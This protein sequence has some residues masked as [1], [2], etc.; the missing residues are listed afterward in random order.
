MPDKPEHLFSGP[1]G[2]TERHSA[3]NCLFCKIVRGEVES[4]RVFEDSVSLAF[5]DHRPLFPG[6][7]L[8]LPKQHYETLADLPAELV[9]PFFLNAQLLCRAVETA[10]QAEGT[11]AGINNCVSQSVPHLH[12]HI[13]PRRH[14]DGMR[15]FFWPRTAYRAPEDA[16]RAQQAI[17]A[18][19]ARLRGEK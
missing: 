18:A 7:C 17:Q 3:Q 16:L 2:R 19:V 8:L 12:M 15:G 14:K 9:A 11:F 6:H 1:T 10:M 5:L 13:V 4:Y